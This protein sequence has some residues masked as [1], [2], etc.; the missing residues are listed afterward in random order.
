MLSQYLFD[1]VLMSRSTYVRIAILYQNLQCQRESVRL[2]LFGFKMALD[3]YVYWL[4]PLSSLPLTLARRRY[5]GAQLSSNSPKASF[6]APMSPTRS[7]GGLPA[8][9]ICSC[10]ID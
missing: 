10:T 7:A 8:A 1:C 2:E 6:V 3:V 5:W 4:D 9:C